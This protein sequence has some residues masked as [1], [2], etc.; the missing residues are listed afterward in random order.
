MTNHFL[1]GHDSKC[2]IAV[3]F[4]LQPYNLSMIIYEKIICSS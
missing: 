4:H 2:D 1:L 3:F